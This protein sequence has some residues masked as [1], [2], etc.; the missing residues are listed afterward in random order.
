MTPRELLGWAVTWRQAGRGGLDALRTAW[1][2]P[3]ED[4]AEGRAALAGPTGA[5]VP[6][7]WRNRITRGEVQLRFGRDRLWYRLTRRGGDWVLDGA[8]SPVPVAPPARVAAR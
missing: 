6:R 1:Q 3:P 2:P 8:P 5:G 7:A 4:L